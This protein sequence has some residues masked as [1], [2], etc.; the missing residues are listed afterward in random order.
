M[1]LKKATFSTLLCLLAL[2]AGNINAVAQKLTPATN[3]AITFTGRTVANTADGSVTF[4]WI[5]THLSTIFN[6]SSVAM[7]VS[8][9]GTSYYNIFIDNQPARKIKVTGKAPQVVQLATKLAKGSHRLT[10]QKCT[11]GEYGCGTIYGLLTADGR[12]TAPTPKKRLIEV[13]GDSYTCGYGTEAKS[14]SE[15]FTLETE[16][17]NKAYTCIISRY[18]DA[19]YVMIAHSGQGIVRNYGDKVQ[20]SK[21]KNMGTRSLQIFDEHDTLGYD[22]KGYRPDMVIIC[23]G[24]NDMSPIC[25]PTTDMFCKGY[26]QLIQRIKAAYG[27]VPVF[28][29]T[30]HSANNYLQEN[31][32]ELQRRTVGMG[33]IIFTPL[34]TRIVREDTDLGADWHPNYEGQRKIAMT[35]IPQISYVMGWPMKGEQE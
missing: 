6:G 24:T 15:H 35:L 25:P 31:M 3:P 12:L 2:S 1:N 10:V 21:P 14:K 22:F 7:K 23:L 17:C 18:F 5:G 29:V 4:D 33:R 9:T 16:N 8:D 26:I 13:Y 28:C 34:M 19:D 20:Q 27:D 32:R 11:E 30:P